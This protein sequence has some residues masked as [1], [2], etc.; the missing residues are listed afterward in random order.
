MAVN[1]PKQRRQRRRCDSR[2]S[3]RRAKGRGPRGRQFLPR[4]GGQ[5][6]DTPVIEVVGQRQ[7]LV[8]AKSADIGRLAV[9]AKAD[10]VLLDLDNE[11]MQPVR[12]PLRSLIFTAADRAVRD[13]FVDGRQVVRERRVLTL[14]RRA[15]LHRLCEA[16][17]RLEAGVPDNDYAGRSSLEITPLSLPMA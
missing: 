4:L 7:R 11:L 15:A 8:A 14:D 5:A 12:D 13:V 17:R 16:Q 2:D 3:R 1:E 10:L 6:A 9:G